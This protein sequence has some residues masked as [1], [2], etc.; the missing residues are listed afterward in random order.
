MPSEV[1]HCQVIGRRAVPT[2]P[3]GSECDERRARGWNAGSWIRFRS[4]CRSCSFWDGRRFKIEC[5]WAA[6]VAAAAIAAVT[7]A[8]GSGV[9]ALTGKVTYPVIYQLGPFSL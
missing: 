8:A 1:A 7:V 9:S 3:A 5:S 4:L 6:L 2:T